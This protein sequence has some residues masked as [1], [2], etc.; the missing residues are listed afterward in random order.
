MLLDK[1]TITKKD[2]TDEE[3]HELQELII[4]LAEAKGFKVSSM[5]KYEGMEEINPKMPFNVDD[6]MREDEENQAKK[7]FTNCNTCED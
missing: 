7:M 3:L 5:L 2:K 6:T 1:I 4:F